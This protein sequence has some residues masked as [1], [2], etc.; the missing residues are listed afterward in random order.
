MIVATPSVTENTIPTR[1]ESRVIR[2]SLRS[3]LSIVWQNRWL[4][5]ILALVTGIGTSAYMFMQPDEYTAEVTM[6]P[7]QSNSGLGFL[8]QLVN[9]S[10]ADPIIDATYE[11]LYA[12]IVMSDHVLDQILQLDWTYKRSAEP[13][14]I[15][16][17]L[18]I[19]YDANDE[20]ARLRAHDRA[21]DRFRMQILTFNR[22]RMTGFMTLRVTVQDYPVLAAEIANFIALAL[23]EYNRQLHVAKA[24]AQHAFIEDRLVETDRDLVAAEAAVTRFIENNRS[25]QSS[26]SLK[27]KYGELRREVTAQTS[28][29]VELR[30][31]LEVAK[32]D[33]SKEMVSVFVL[34]SAS[35]PFRPSG[36]RRILVSGLAL[37]FGASLGVL[38]ALVREQLAPTARFAH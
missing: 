4:I 35:V 37:F 14:S 34:D 31:Q 22:E 27:Q 20:R 7:Q 19:E 17:I 26:P 9:L 1:S 21:K 6:L 3:L 28:I 38:V 32:I 23:D 16:A 10:G 13:A 24:S 8:S 18:D 25:Y 11:E 29:W 2:F 12:K 5:A 30:R 36:P 15:F 33:E